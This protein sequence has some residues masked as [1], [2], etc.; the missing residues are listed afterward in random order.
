MTQKSAVFIYFVAEAWNHA[1][2]RVTEADVFLQYISS[3]QVMVATM[4]RSARV[5]T[6]DQISMLSISTAFT[7]AM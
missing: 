5:W 6:M 4:D 1:F 3:I 7:G 2:L